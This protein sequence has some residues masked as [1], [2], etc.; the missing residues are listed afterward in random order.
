MPILSIESLRHFERVDTM[1]SGWSKAKEIAKE[2]GYTF[3][4]RDLRHK[5][6]PNF[7]VLYCWKEVPSKLDTSKTDFLKMQII[8]EQKSNK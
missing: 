7:W 3:E 2:H 6:S 8:I 5:S 1:E 4:K